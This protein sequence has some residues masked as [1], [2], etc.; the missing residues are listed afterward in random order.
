MPARRARIA[1]EL[2][3]AFVQTEATAALIYYKLKSALPNPSEC[4]IF[5]EGQKVLCIWS[6]CIAE[7]LLFPVRSTELLLPAG[8]ACAQGGTPGSPGPPPQGDTAAHS[9]WEDAFAAIISL[10]L[11]PCRAQGP[12]LLADQKPSLHFLESRNYGIL[13]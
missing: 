6:K 5:T 2:F 13:H 10:F 12:L 9:L 3:G 4:L 11:L 1:P 8:A 7:W